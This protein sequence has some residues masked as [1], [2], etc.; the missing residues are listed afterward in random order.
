VAAFDDFDDAALV[1]AATET[2]TASAM[3]TASAAGVR[4]ILFIV[5]KASGD[6]AC[7]SVLSRQQGNRL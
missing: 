1:P 6:M 3:A 2:S 7:M 5:R 4:G